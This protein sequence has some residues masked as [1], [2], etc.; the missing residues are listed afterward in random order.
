MADA[1]ARSE[2]CSDARSE[3]AADHAYFLEL[4]DLFIDLRGAPLMLSPS[5]WQVAKAWRRRGIPLELVRRVLREVFEKRKQREADDIVSLRYFRR[6]V[7]GTWKKARELAAGGERAEPEAFD[8]EGRLER[9]AAALPEELPERGR[10]VERI[11]LLGG[12]SAD[13]GAGSAERPE[14]DMEAVEQALERLDDELLDAVGRSLDAD[15]TE[16]LR[17]RVEEA[18]GRLE[19]RLPQEEMSRSRD[20]LRRRLLREHMSLPV[21]SLFSPAAEGG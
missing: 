17:R 10:W 4:E 16:T 6:P 18:L 14:P 7:E 21:L 13:A 11:R 8:L 19:A 5:D 12:D 2:T 3:S 9:L 1:E 15:K 20:H